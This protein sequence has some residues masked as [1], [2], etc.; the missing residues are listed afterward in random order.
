MSGRK[1]DEVHLIRLQ[2]ERV[3]HA[4]KLNELR[5]ICYKQAVKHGWHE[6]TRSVGDLIALMHSELS[7]ALEE[8]RKGKKPD[9]VYYNDPP[10]GDPHA[11]HKAYSKPEG[12]PIELADVIIRIFDFCGRYDIDIDKAIALKIAYNDLRPY[13]HGGKVL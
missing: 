8:H 11:L 13:R 1:I 10:L 12:I 3:E 9:E 4:M 7:E 5:D 2:M 6:T